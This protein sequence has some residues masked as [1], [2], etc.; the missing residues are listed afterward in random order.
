MA[1]K[2]NNLSDQG[3][4]IIGTG[5]MA[6]LFGA[7]LA[8][9]GKDVYMLGSWQAAIDSINQDGLRLIDQNGDISSHKV[10]A[11]S[12]EAD[13]KG[14]AN[15][16][17]LVKAWQ[18]KRAAQQLRLILP[19]NGLA[20]SLQNG[21]GNAEILGAELGDQRVA[22]GSTIIGATLQGPGIVRQSS[23]GS[24]SLG[25]HPRIDFL[26]QALKDARF[27]LQLVHDLDALLWKKLAINAAINPLTA[28]LEIPNGKLLEDD[29]LMAWMESLALEVAKVAAASGINFSLP[30]P[31]ATAKEVARKTADNRSSMFQDILR[32]APTEIDA[33]CGA[34][35]D[36][37]KLA[38]VDTPANQ[39]MLALI[40][41]KIG[42]Q[43]IKLENLDAI[44]LS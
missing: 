38:G 41:A 37:G 42:G 13:C 16:L 9:N 3:I 30:D 36:A 44:P 22:L 34:V 40:K 33:I 4:L 20:L 39:H 21:L 12:N 29:E 14:I 27:D 7:R 2:N 31:F 5:A 10:H 11:T 28:L 35:V 32:G 25:N 19:D 24:I 6:S 26:S 8:A 23:E 18:S 15:A 1:I 43:I 17:V